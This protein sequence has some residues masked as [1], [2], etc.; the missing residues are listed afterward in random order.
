MLAKEYKSFPLHKQTDWDSNSSVK[1][2]YYRARAPYITQKPM[3]YNMDDFCVLLLTF[4]W[5]IQVC[6]HYRL[7]GAIP[8]PKAMWNRYANTKMN[9]ERGRWG[10]RWSWEEDWRRR[11]EMGGRIKDGLRLRF[12]LAVEVCMCCICALNMRVFS[13]CTKLRDVRLC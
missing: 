2:F 5:Y 13:A 7:E 3:P 11:G 9:R 4:L 1:K 8:F 10:W 6:Y 12:R